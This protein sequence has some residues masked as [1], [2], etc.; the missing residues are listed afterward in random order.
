MR[1][2]AIYSVPTVKVPPIANDHLSLLYSLNFPFH[3]I[4]SRAQ[5]EVARNLSHTC[6]FSSWSYQLL[7]KHC[8]HRSNL[9]LRLG[10]DIPPRPCRL[11]RKARPPV[12]ASTAPTTF[13]ARQSEKGCFFTESPSRPD[14]A[15]LI[16]A[17]STS[18]WPNA[19]CLA[20]V[21]ALTRD[22]ALSLLGLV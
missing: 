17:Y 19:S 2:T 10:T 11:L 20:L 9:T 5:I 1:S 14:D 12:F 16:A 18:T 4:E 6:V 15:W 22:S 8:A 7:A 21:E 13:F 3:L